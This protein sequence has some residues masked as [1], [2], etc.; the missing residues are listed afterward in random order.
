MTLGDGFHAPERDE[1]GDRFAW[2]STAGRLH[3]PSGATTLQ[4]RLDVPE[5]LAG[6]QLQL[7]GRTHDLAPGPLALTL[8]TSAPHVRLT[9]DRRH[10]APGD[11]R[12]MSLRI[13]AAWVEGPAFAPAYGR[14]SPGHPRT[15]RARDV[16]LEGFEAPE[17][18][19]HDR[20]GAWT[21]ADAEAS[22][23]ARPGTIYVRLARP[24]HTPG[25]VT[26][27]SDAEQ[28]VLEIGPNVDT[29]EL[30]ECGTVRFS[31]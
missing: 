30:P 3:L 17:V 28:K 11:P 13:D 6:A 2:M 31:E 5:D 21:R 8:S 14:W 10:Q 18:F 9:V 16:S 26:I 15:L 12:P 29:V 19:A 4:L 1:H 25:H 7:E 23:P 24:P 27:A 20:R 22:F